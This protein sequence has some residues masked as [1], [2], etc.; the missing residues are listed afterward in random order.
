MA[1]SYCLYDYLISP[2]YE[3]TKLKFASIGDTIKFGEYKENRGE[4]TVI[5]KE[6]DKALI[7]YNGSDIQMPYNEDYE[8]VSWDDCTLKE[9]LN[10]EYYENSF[11]EIEKTHIMNTDNGKVFLLTVEEAETYFD[12][13]S[14]RILC[15]DINTL[16]SDNNLQ[17]WLLSLENDRCS[18]PIVNREGEVDS[19]GS[20][21]NYESN[22][23]R[24]AMWIEISE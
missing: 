22:Y 18:S 17:W 6:N 21:V 12:Q 16:D 2:S 20:R 13:N 9:W 1:I 5:E 23:V 10:L 14:Q 8:E 4:W 24:P 7:L 15:K 11:Q 19:I 3:L